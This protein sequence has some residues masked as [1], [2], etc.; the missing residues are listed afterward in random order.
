MGFAFILI[1]AVAAF[2][3]VPLFWTGYVGDDSADSLI[4]GAIRA[5]G[6]GI[7]EYTAYKVRASLRSARFFPLQMVQLCL[8]LYYAQDV[9]AYKAIVIA[10]VVLD[11]GLFYAL[12][13]RL[14]DSR[15]FA[16]FGACVVV[17]LFQFRA[18]FDP[19]LS[20]YGLLQA[21]M[22]L[23]LG[24]LL[25][26]QVSLDTGRR[27]WLAV[28][29]ACF[30]GALLEYEVVLPLFVM[31]G[32]MVCHARRALWDRVRLTA[33]FV[34]ASVFCLLAFV[35]LRGYFL[36]PQSDYQVSKDPIA[37]LLAM[38]R[39]TSSGLPLS[40]FATN[41]FGMF[42]PLWKPLQVVRFAATPGGLAVFAGVIAACGHGL[43]AGFDD[44]RG[45]TRGRLSLVGLL[46]LCLAVLPA[47]LVCVSVRH[48]KLIAFGIGYLPVYIQYFGVAMVLASLG[49]GLLAAIPRRAG[50]RAVAATALALLVGTTGAVNYR[51]NALLAELL[52][53]GPDMAGFQP[54]VGSVEAC[55][56]R[57]R[58]NLE[59]ALH[60]GL[61]DGVPEDSDL[62]LENDYPSWHNQSHGQY[63]YALHSGKVVNTVSLG[64]RWDTEPWFLLRRNNHGGPRRWS[65]RTYRLRDVCLDARTGYV[66]LE[67]VFP[68]EPSAE[69]TVFVRHPR[70]YR[71]GVPTFTITGTKNGEE[72]RTAALVRYG[73]ELETVRA[74]RDWG[75]FRLGPAMATV[76]SR[77]L[78]VSIGNIAT[79]WG[80]SFFER[81]MDEGHPFRWCGKEGAVTIHNATDRP[82]KVVVSMTLQNRGGGP[83]VVSGPTGNEEIRHAEGKV[84]FVREVVLAPGE[85]RIEFVSDSTTFPTPDGR[86]LYFRI[87]DFRID[88]GGPV[89]A[90]AAGTAAAGRS[91]R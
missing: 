23:M 27:R 69:I 4:A 12:L 52:P 25:A 48:Q 11:V 31:H 38:A 76:D 80:R 40:Y 50:I 55:F 75:V 14:S 43:R 45:P 24:S 3:M 46:G 6:F 63:F 49:W 72:N 32:V 9:T 71:E 58:R 35:S 5:E 81:E 64:T 91:R 73:R 28:S 30:L 1:L 56:N 16:V 83:I 86:A 42:P 87:Y 44:P 47:A 51:A 77:S 8:L 29:L 78:A 79:E 34:G 57:Q 84:P 85:N 53:I 22:V 17:T 37:F 59:E 60:A 82:R 54:V 36:P 67:R 7:F 68:P 41:H 13:R 15:G 89:A 39:Q 66:V 33:P 70:L 61:L 19:I 20:F 10:G 65:G 88:D 21:V 2:S 90:L 18:F 74:G 26:L 62:V